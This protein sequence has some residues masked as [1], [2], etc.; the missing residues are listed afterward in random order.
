MWESSGVK[1]ADASST[2]WIDYG[3]GAQETGL[4]NPARFFR[5]T[6][7][8]LTTYLLLIAGLLAVRGG[9]VP[10]RWLLI[11]GHFLLAAA[12]FWLFRKPAADSRWRRFAQSWYFVPVTVFLFKEQALM[13][14]RIRGVDFDQLLINW[15]YRLF[16]VYPTVYLERFVH[17]LLTELLQWAYVAYFFL[18]IILGVFLLRLRDSRPFE[19]AAFAVIL[20]F[21]ISL[22]GYLVVPAIGP[23]FTLGH[24]Q[25]VSLHGIW[26]ADSIR[27]V[28]NQLEQIQRDCFPSGHTML[29]LVTLFYALKYFP[30][31][32]VVFSP[33]VAA[34]IF[35]TVY[36]RYHY[37]VDV[38]AGMALAAVSVLVSEWAYGDLRLRIALPQPI[39]ELLQPIS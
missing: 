29:A 7:F 2:G 19:N 16:G 20:S 18:P 5:P 28:L 39:R 30:R 34:L 36:L 8:L 13:V 3:R 4:R 35:S 25:T 23:R 14:T 33:I 24:L 1:T 32:G 10:Y 9:S 6:E 38:L 17:P 22:S 21:C 12:I 37:A 11:A 26:L 27:S 31:L 15:D